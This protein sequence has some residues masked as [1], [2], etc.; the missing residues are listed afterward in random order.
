MLNFR[1]RLVD[2]CDPQIQ[3]EIQRR[4]LKTGCFL[5][6]LGRIWE[7]RAN[8]WKGLKEI[9]VLVGKFCNEQDLLSEEECTFNGVGVFRV[10]GYE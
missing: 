8:G 9:L 2:L 7:L 5:L 4:N 1:L 6:L 10:N 3:S